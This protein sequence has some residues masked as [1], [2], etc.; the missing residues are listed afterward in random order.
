MA[1]GQS[2]CIPLHSP[3]NHYLQRFEILSGRIS[4]EIHFS[5]PPYVRMKAI[6]FL[7]SAGQYF[8]RET[9]G[10]RSGDDRMVFINPIDQE[11]YEFL[12][13][14]NDEWSDYEGAKSKK[15]IFKYF[16]RDK[17]TLYQYRSDDFLVKINPV[18]DFEIGKES[19]MD[20]ILF[21]NT[22]GIN[23]RGWI[24]KR[25]GYD[26]YLTENQARYPT[27]VQERTDSFD[28]LPSEGYFKEFKTDGV[29]FFDAKG[30]FN[31]TAAKF[32]MIQ[33]GHE[34]NFLGNGIRSLALS[35][36]SED[37]LFLKLQTQ[38]WKISYQN[39]FMDLTADFLRGGDQLYPKK[40]AAAHHLS[41]NA[42]K[43]LNVGVWES[44]IFHREDG[45]ELN[46]LNPI[47]F[48]RSI[49]QLMGSPDNT[50][51]GLDYRV[52]FLRRFSWYGQV[53][54]DD[55]NF[56]A[57][58]GENGYW[59]N[60]FGIQQ[61]IKY[62]NAFSLLNLDLQA[63]WNIVRPYTYTQKDTVTHYSNYNQPLA[64]PLGA[65]FNEVIG[66]ARYQ[67]I[68][69][70]TITGKFIYAVQGRDTSGSNWGANIFIPTTDKNV[71]TIYDN[72]I[73]QGVKSH[74]TLFSLTASYMVW[75]NFF[76]DGSFCF[77][78]STSDFSA[79]ESNTNFFSIGVR[80]NIERRE[81]LF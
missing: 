72:E 67:P 60:K 48:Y 27:Y 7:D 23:V 21:T 33:F 77:R 62:M 14:D 36:A 74:L 59:A 71:E 26:F 5:T 47:I 16:Y 37:Y 32:I 78:K 45:F 76:V 80:M 69:P 34:K 66:M 44:V 6:Q 43:W 24:A 49:E 17:A 52:N 28:A 65:N 29:D 55:Y 2:N 40:F 18:F 46:Y 39:L 3:S 56:Q 11:S 79:F 38:V 68:F 19:S 70:L 22:R 8:F 20:E 63:E 9:P 73:A 10:G 42:T 1:F 35:D 57:S 50:M 4:D 58:K 13:T 61:G 41:I 81:F 15:P 25:V 75:H 30:Y 51:I 31:F 54:L 64:H 12:K 53:S